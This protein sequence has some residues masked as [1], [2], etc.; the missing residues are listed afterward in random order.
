[1]TISASDWTSTTDPF[2]QCDVSINGPT[3]Y[4]SVS[5]AVG[6][7]LEGAIN[8]VHDDPDVQEI[9][10]RETTS[11]W[12][13]IAFDGFQLQDTESYAVNGEFESDKRPY[14][15]GAYYVSVFPLAA[16]GTS[17]GYDDSFY[18]WG[19]FVT[20]SS[21]GSETF[22]LA[23][24]T[25]I[26][27]PKADPAQIIMSMLHHYIPNDYGSYGLRSFMDQTSFQ[28]ASSDFYDQRTLGVERTGYNMTVIR[29]V[30]TTIK[31]QIEEIIKQT[32]DF[33]AVRPTDDDGKAELHYVR[34]EIATQ[35]TT[36]I[37]FDDTDSGVQDWRGGIDDN[38]TVHEIEYE[39]GAWVTAIDSS[40]LSTFVSNASVYEPTWQS[41]PD[42]QH[43][44]YKK[45]HVRRFDKDVTEIKLPDVLYGYEIDRFWHIYWWGS[46][47]EDI[48]FTQ[49][50]R[51]FNYEIG[52]IVRIQST[53]LG[54]DGSEFFLVYEK[55]VD[56]DT[57]HAKVRVQ[58]VY[59]YRGE[60]PDRVAGTG[61]T[62]TRWHYKCDTLGG[63]PIG[64]LAHYPTATWQP[65]LL[66]DE[67]WVD[68][69]GW[70]A[71][72]SLVAS[73]SGSGEVLRSD[74][75]DSLNGWPTLDMGDPGNGF[76]VDYDAGSSTTEKWFYIV[77]KHKTGTFSGD[78][79]LF[80]ATNGADPE[81]S[82]MLYDGT[83]TASQ[84]FSGGSN[85]GSVQLCDDTD[86]HIYAINLDGTSGTIWEGTTVLESLTIAA[87]KTNTNC[88][89]FSYTGTSLNAE[90]L[91]TE[92]FWIQ[93][94]SADNPISSFDHID[95]VEYL[96]EKYGL[97]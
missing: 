24:E 72:A 61:G 20:T 71:N 47:Q 45:T 9:Y 97:D 52:D 90:I 16:D 66:L 73:V 33:L 34:R 84:V 39:Y 78:E 60:R 37:N 5:E 4:T 22:G 27:W 42:L 89:L 76:E 15:S 69:S 75:A 85:D 36:K 93:N 23:V 48:T 6:T 53:K 70:K 63:Q 7:F 2:R 1:M 43:E 57:L 21:T 35:R 95:I 54:L 65:R 46:D 25:A 83:Y 41:P 29:K 80:R 12:R 38:L 51:H 19:R 49:G 30:G 55:Y 64:A 82:I 74:D 79:Y 28:N 81:L 58:R 50:P 3:D 86:W 14:G 17:E 31:K 26:H 96:R 32:P 67:V 10:L 92:T 11:P 13:R 40:S 87:G 91:V 94:T 44:G 77:C 68:S 8:G 59:G 56:L 62:Y 88:Y 18:A